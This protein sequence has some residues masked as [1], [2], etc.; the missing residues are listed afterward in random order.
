M[1]TTSLC[2]HAQHGSGAVIL[3]ASQKP[4]KRKRGGRSAAAIAAR[5]ERGYLKRTRTAGGTACD[6]SN[7]VDSRGTGTDGSGH[8]LNAR[9]QQHQ[10]AV[11]ILTS[12]RAS[13]ARQVQNLTATSTSTPGQRVRAGVVDTRVIGKPEQ[14]DGHP[15]KYAGWSFKL[16]SY[17][18]AVDQRYEQELT[19][20][21]ASSTLRLNANLGSEGSALSTQMYYILPRWTSVTTTGV[22]EGFEAR[23]QFVMEWELKLRTRFLELLMNVI[24]TDS[25]T[26]F[27]TSWR[28]SRDS[29]TTTRTN[30]QRP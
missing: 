15:M 24:G 29:C 27:R 4:G 25:E 19:T 18:R 21:E 11:T 20:T 17:L 8:Q 7:H 10:T 6:Q 9:L 2:V 16:R 5:I 26:T 3:V 1:N 30:Q 22:N 23:R 14:F 13:L 12:E 28:R